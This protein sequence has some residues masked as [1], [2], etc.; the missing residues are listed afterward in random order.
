MTEVAVKASKDYKILIDRGLFSRAGELI[1]PLFSGNRICLV[2]GDTVEGLYAEKVQKS[3]EAQGILVNRFVYPHGE[4]SKSA[5]TYIALLNHL[6]GCEMDRS[7]LIVALG[8][9]VTGDLAGFAAATYMRGIKYVQMPTTLLAMVDS[10]VGGKTAIDLCGGKN[11][12]GAFWQPEM[13]IC[14]MDAL[15]T[16]PEEIFTDGC[17]EVIKYGILKDPEILE[18]IKSPRENIEELISRCV[19]IKRDIVAQDEFD[20][21]QRQLLNLGHTLGHAV[22]KLSDFKI[23]HGRGVAIGLA[24][25]LRA[26]AKKNFC[27]E[28]TAKR[29]IL[30][31]KSLNLPTKTHFSAS[32][33]TTAIMSDKKRFGAKIAIIVPFEIGR[34][35]IESINL[36]DVTKFIKMGL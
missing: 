12:A 2:C 33:L 36:E 10:S 29:G 35:G 7:D 30:A 13:V 9:G 20:K 27:S 11:L 16:L 34:C 15:E 19:T 14:D 25:F 21:G 24:V 4:K 18:L 17:G 22:E 3:L 5:E 23:S 26:S 1:R 28:N 8:G 6:A 31:L 32:E